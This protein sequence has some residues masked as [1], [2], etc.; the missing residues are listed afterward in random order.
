[1]RRSYPDLRYKYVRGLIRHER[2]QRRH[3]F[4]KQAA[5][6][7]SKAIVSLSLADVPIR[8]VKQAQKLEGVGGVICRKLK[9][10]DDNESISA[11]APR[12]GRYISSAAAL[13]VAMLNACEDLQRQ[14]GKENVLV[15]E[16]VLREFA[17]P[18][19][20]EY[21]INNNNR[22]EPVFCIAWWRLTVLISRGY[23]KKRSKNKKPVYE[24]L[25]DG[26]EV[27]H[28]L[29]G[30]TPVSDKA[31]LPELIDDV[32]SK[33]GTSLNSSY[34][35]SR[36][37]NQ[38]TAAKLSSDALYSNDDGSD[39]VLL[40][41]DIHEQGG[42]R[43]K[44]G[45]LSQSLTEIG[46]RHKTRHL[47]CGDYCWMWRCHGE[48]R[49]LPVLVERKRA[50]D[51]AWS[52][53]DGRYFRQKQQMLEWKNTYPSQG[54]SV[55]LQYIIESKPESYRVKCGDDCQGVAKCGNPSV[56]Q[57]NVGCG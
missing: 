53:K 18:I 37:P 11:D 40:L 46:V 27:A 30:T 14:T 47:S 35:Q 5:E 2:D 24:L 44:L 26:F 49:I 42:D 4:L 41:I 39:G 50:D 29:R 8:S 36:S 6:W 9:E 25:D 21:F 32:E 48:E 54:V 43:C 57:V 15:P 12:N 1:M 23:I 38:T 28:Q 20:E 33:P 17:A 22:D 52:L 13:M 31:R 55:T 45:E 3:H 56:D 10:I 34:S 19:C 51:L 16:D 7:T